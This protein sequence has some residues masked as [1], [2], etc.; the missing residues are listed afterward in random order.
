MGVGGAGQ[1]HQTRHRL[2]QPI[3][4]THEQPVRRGSTPNK[5][6]SEKKQHNKQNK[7]KETQKKSAGARDGPHIYKI[8]RRAMSTRSPSRIANPSSWKCSSSAGTPKLDSFCAG[9]GG[10]AR[11]APWPQFGLPH[12]AARLLLGFSHPGLGHDCWRVV[13]QQQA[14]K[15]PKSEQHSASKSAHVCIPCHSRALCSGDSSTKSSGRNN[16]E[17]CRYVPVIHTRPTHRQMA[18]AIT[19]ATQD[20]THMLDAVVFDTPHG[21]VAVA[22]R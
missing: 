6:T 3:R 5:T 21:R 2:M 16:R 10:G 4:R 19:G 1:G 8:V 22:M 14:S 13:K 18:T 11:P 7:Q 9:L 15:R 20:E 12:A 17:G